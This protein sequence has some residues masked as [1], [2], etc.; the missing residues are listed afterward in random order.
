MIDQTVYQEKQVPFIHIEDDVSHLIPP[1]IH[2][3]GIRSPALLM[4]R[5]QPASKVLSHRVGEEAAF[6]TDRTNSSGESS[7]VYVSH[8]SP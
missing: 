4:T 5:Y 7:T 6:A 1:I 8:G 2:S 3:V